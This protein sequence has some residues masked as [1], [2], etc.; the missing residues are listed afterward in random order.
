MARKGENIHKRKDG[1]WE[2][3]YKNGYKKDGSVKY[4]SVYAKSYSECKLKL[5][6]AKFDKKEHK[7]VSGNILFKDITFMWMENN[8]IRLK[9]STLAKYENVI[10]THIIPEMGEIKF[11]HIDSSYIN[12]FLYR[13]MQ[14]GRIGTGGSLS[15]SYVK[16]MAVIIE[17]IIKYGRK[18]GYNQKNNITV[19]KPQT[20]QK[21]ILTMSLTQEKDLLKVL[22][23]EKNAVTIG[24][25][26]A[27]QAGLRI[28]EVCALKWS[29]IDFENECIN[30]RHTVSRVNVNN[31]T[32]LIIDT[33]K[34]KSSRRCIPMSKQL[35]I[36]L[37]DAYINRKSEFV[38]SD[39]KDFVSTRTFEY[40]Y[41]RMLKRNNL[42]IFNFHVLRHTFATRCAEIGMDAKALSILLGHST[43]I[44]TLSIYIHPSMELVKQKIDNIFFNKY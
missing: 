29:D 3:R 20:E 43:P 8:K 17:A 10:K 14:C 21:D 26:I 16:T 24:T 28:G 9:G 4:A 33:P 11:S 25:L 32:C 12:D 39:N 1:R 15:T 37:G 30:V 42:P 6:K 44:T 36:A 18:E 23:Q 27:L 41:K 38:V 13:K 35:K 19:F 40:Q 22:L 34:T 5:E 7:S 2:G 31:K